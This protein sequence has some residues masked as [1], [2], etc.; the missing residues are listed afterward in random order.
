MRRIVRAGGKSI[1]YELIKTG[2]QSVEIRV[3]PEGIRV[4]A[5]THTALKA[6]DAMVIERAD[7]IEEAQHRLRQYADDRLAEYP[8]TNGMTFPLEGRQV[9][10]RLIPGGG[11]FRLEGDIFYLPTDKTE[12]AAVSEALSQALIA[13]FRE[14]LDV[15]LKKYVPLVGRSPAHIAVR[16]QKTRWGSCSGKGNLNFNWKLIMA[17]PEALTY[18][19]I[20]ELCHLW[21]FNHSDRFWRRVAVYQPEYAQWRDFLRSGWRHPF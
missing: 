16:G 21:E 7:W 5:P 12:P 17:P 15:Q 19:V 1:E 11:S 13:L 20:H 2:R 18:V 3:L 14:R 6:A 4:F 8:M 10:L 9:T